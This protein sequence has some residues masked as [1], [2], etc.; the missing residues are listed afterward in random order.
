MLYIVL[1]TLIR[2]LFCYSPDW[3]FSTCRVSSAAEVVFVQE[4]KE[5]RYT[6]HKTEK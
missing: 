1:I 2:A 6:D 5:K 4:K 3:N